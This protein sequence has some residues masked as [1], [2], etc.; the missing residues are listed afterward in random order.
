MHASL[1]QI[2]DIG[3]FVSPLP[4]HLAA[5]TIIYGQAC[6]FTTLSY[7]TG[8]EDVNSALH[9]IPALRWQWERKDAGGGVHPVTLEL[10]NKVFKKKPPTSDRPKLI[11]NFLPEED[12]EDDTGRNPPPDA[13]AQ[14]GH[15]PTELFLAGPAWP[16]RHEIN[17]TRGDGSNSSDS[18][19]PI[20]AHAVVA[21]PPLPNGPSNP[22]VGTSLLNANNAYPKEENIDLTNIFAHVPG[23]AY[24]AITTQ[25][26]KDLQEFFMQEEKDPVAR[27]PWIRSQP[28]P[29]PALVAQYQHMVSVAIRARSLAPTLVLTLITTSRA[30]QFK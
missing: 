16:E 9:I 25:P 20:G 13:H 7:E 18:A 2:P 17:Q 6:G 19:S 11:P 4:L 26:E 10:A 15:W 29:V 27:P 30:S 28:E 1:T 12:W 3:F 22:S 21:Q 23:Y 24:G 14:L 5:I 8:F